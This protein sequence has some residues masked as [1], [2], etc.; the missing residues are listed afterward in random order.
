MLMDFKTIEVIFLSAGWGVFYRYSEEITREISFF[1]G[2]MGTRWFDVSD[3]V[4][5][6]AVVDRTRQFKRSIIFTVPRDRLEKTLVEW[7]SQVE[8]EYKLFCL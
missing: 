8:T 6:M 3:P 5:G 1:K 7:L 2:E 4:V